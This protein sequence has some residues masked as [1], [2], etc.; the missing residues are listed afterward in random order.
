MVCF[1]KMNLKKVIDS[2]KH[3]G[4]NVIGVGCKARNFMNALAG[5]NRSR[6]EAEKQLEMHLSRFSTKNSINRRSKMAGQGTT[7]QSESNRSL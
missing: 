3:M 1:V 7:T 6:S 2:Y 5:V 4:L